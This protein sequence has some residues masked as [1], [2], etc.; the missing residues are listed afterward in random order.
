M[1]FKLNLCGIEMNMRIKGYR[2][3]DK[4]EWD[5]QWCNVDFSFI[6]ESWL[7]YQRDDD[8]VLLA[9]EVE[10]LADSLDML[11]TDKLSEIKTIDCIEPDF[12]FVLHP[13]NDLRN[14]PKY[15]YIQKG[16]EINDI[17]MEM[18]IFFWYEGLTDNFLTVTFDR[19]DI[20]YLRNYLFLII[21]KVGK[22]D[23][24]IKDML[25]KGILVKEYA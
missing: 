20:Q 9:S 1:W 3:S 19:T 13:K 8:E 17:Y 14:D 2:P 18:E 21:G 15:T 12:H 24:G 5:C 6:G 23:K 25:N 16:C 22:D 11:L 7:K 10:E 4:N